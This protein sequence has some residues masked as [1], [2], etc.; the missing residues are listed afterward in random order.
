[1]VDGAHQVGE[2]LEG[3]VDE[4]QGEDQGGHE[5][6]GHEVHPKPKAEPQG[7]EAQGHLHPEVPL[8]PPGVGEALPCV[9]E[10]PEDPF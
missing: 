8:D 7:E 3:R 4:L 5:E 10:G 6:D 2:G 9:A 1:M